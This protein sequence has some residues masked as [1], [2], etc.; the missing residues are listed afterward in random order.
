M[1]EP[2]PVCDAIDGLIAWSDVG[3]ALIG[4]VCSLILLWA[5]A[6]VE[7]QYQWRTLRRSAWNIAKQHISYDRQ[8]DDLERL[9]ASVRIGGVLISSSDFSEHYSALISDLA[10]LDA[11]NADTYIEFLS[12]E[13][14]VRS[15]YQRLE[16]FKNEFIKA[17]SAA[18][19]P[20]DE[21]VSLRSALHGQID[22]LRKDL[23]SMATCEL[24]VLR[25]IQISRAD[26]VDTVKLLEASIEQMGKPS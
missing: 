16:F 6:A 8:L 25:R 19:C 7:R 21:A 5:K 12:K 9:D 23:K 15:G 17:R 26:A 2:I 3:K 22:V 1:N 4:F 11:R 13:A 18:P 14:V 24:Q 20:T 10:R